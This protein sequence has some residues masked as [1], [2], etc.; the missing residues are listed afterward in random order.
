MRRLQKKISLTKIIGGRG[1][2]LSK[3]VLLSEKKPLI[4]RDFRKAGS[5]NAMG[6]AGKEGHERH[7]H[8]NA[9][10]FNIVIHAMP[11]E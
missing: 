9:F 11:T 4:S 10:T 6:Q 2:F 1:S 5:I 8:I 3:N 7:F